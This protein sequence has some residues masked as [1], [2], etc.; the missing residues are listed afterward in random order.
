MPEFRS[1]SETIYYEKFGHG[2]G[3]PLVFLHSLGLSSA[4]WTD[5]LEWFAARYMCLAPDCRGH[6]R[7]S[8]GEPITRDA[9]VDDIVGLLDHEGCEAAHVVGISMG[10]VWALRLYE[11]F[12]QRVRSLVLSDTFASVPDPAGAIRL[13]D[14]Q[15]AAKPMAEFSR[16]YFAQVLKQPIPAAR[17]ARLLGVLENTSKTVYAEM[18]RAIFTADAEAVLPSVN[19]PAL[20]LVGAMDDRT[21]LSYAQHLASRIRGARLQVI[22]RAGHLANLDNP[23]DFN[24]ALD[25]FLA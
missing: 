18:T 9:I 21:P 12:R 20:V 2:Q 11:Q 5:Q 14:E 7:S 17:L 6:G 24:A 3:P 15:L 13:R 19:V 4:M 22:S 16:G 25:E 8:H 1:G 10:G 23:Q